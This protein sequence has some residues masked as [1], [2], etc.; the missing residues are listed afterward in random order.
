MKSETVYAVGIDIG[1][2]SL[3]CGIVDANGKLLYTFLFPINKSY[4]Q[5][6]VI[7]L[8]VAAVRKCANQVEGH[9]AGVGIGFPGIIHNN[10]V[11]G[12]ADNLPDFVGVDLGEVITAST[13]LPVCVAN[14]VNMMALG[15]QLYGAAQGCT[16]VVLLTIGTG[17]GGSLL[18]NGQLYSGYRN[19]GGELGH[20]TLVHHGR[21]CACGA[22]G[23]LEAYASV[24]SLTK[25]YAE[26][27]KAKNKLKITG[28]LIVSN[29][30]AGE[31]AA[32]T[33]M[34]EHFDYLSSGIAGLVNIFSPQKVVI[35]GGIS[36]SGSFYVAELERRV[37]QQV[38]PIC[39]KHTQLVAAQLGNKA[40]LLGCAA[41]VFRQQTVSHSLV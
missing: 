22:R 19:F 39:A 17:I 20:T 36:E 12:G 33:A 15:E 4:S 26:L 34:H 9:I 41:E 8:I 21:P 23:C 24:S 35:G 3:K 2:S 6:E 27:N 7:A 18:I 5:G 40:G 25:R 30:L 11:V 29:Y 37:L 13:N 1:G 31:A 32:A 28:K 10:V 38:V 14:D 16:D